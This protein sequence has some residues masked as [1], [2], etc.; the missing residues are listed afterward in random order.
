[1]HNVD[2]LLSKSAQVLSLP[3]TM[4]YNLGPDV[5]GTIHLPQTSLANFPP[6]GLIGLADPLSDK[7]VDQLISNATTV[8]P[9]ALQQVL[10]FTMST[11][12]PQLPG[13]GG[14]AGNANVVLATPGIG[15]ILPGVPGAGGAFGP[16]GVLGGTTGL[17]GGTTSLLGGTL[18]G[19]GGT[20]GGLG[21]GVGGLLGGLGGGGLIGGG[22]GLLGGGG[23]L[24]GGGGGGLLGG[25]GGGLF[26]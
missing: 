24:I 18:G 15:G 17:L 9:T 13:G 25:G 23:G 14:V 1:S 21:G 5:S 6:S 3:T 8:S 4:A 19:L 20:I 22:G 7:S 12:G 16:A 10:P 26:P 2:P 11:L